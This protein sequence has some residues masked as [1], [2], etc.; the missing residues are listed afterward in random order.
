MFTYHTNCNRFQL[1]AE[2]EFHDHCVLKVC[3]VTRGSGNDRHLYVLS[4]GT[5]GQIAIW[6]V[7][8]LLHKYYMECI[9]SEDND[10]SV[11]LESDRSFVTRESEQSKC[12]DSPETDHNESTKIHTKQTRN[13]IGMPEWDVQDLGRPCACITAH[14]SGI[15]ALHVIHT[16]G[17]P[18]H[19]YTSSLCRC[20]SVHY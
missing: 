20:I 15:N 7:T 5:D 14:Q 2:S 1:L 9:N 12:Y 13:Y 3:H 11:N 10:S 16:T 4:A 19:T 18:L 17:E 8:D 6:C